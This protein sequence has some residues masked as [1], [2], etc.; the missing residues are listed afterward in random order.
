MKN[1]KSK[2]LFPISLLAL[3]VLAGCNKYLDR[4]AENRTFAAAIDY[5]KTQDM[6]QPLIGAYAAFRDRG[7]EQFPLVGVRGDDINAGGLGDQPGFMDTDNYKY[8]K[9]NWQYNSVWQTMYRDIL[10]GWASKAQIDLYAEKA[11]GSTPAEQYKA[12]IDVLNCFLLLQISRMWGNVLIPLSANPSDLLAAPVS[13]K[14][15]V[16][17]YISQTMA[18]AAQ[19]L[20]DSRPNQRTDVPGGVTKYTALAIKAIADLD[21][22]N[23]QG[24]A[25]ATGAIINSG[26][27]QLFPDFYQLFKKPGKLSNESLLELQYSDFGSGTG[28]QDVYTTAFFGPQSWKP[29]VGQINGGWAFWEPSF[30]YIKFML[31]RG[32]KTRVL[33]TVLFSPRGIDSLQGYVGNTPLPDWITNVTPSGD[34]INDYTRAVF[35]SGKF[36]LPSEQITPGRTGWANGINIQCIRYAEVLLMYA[37]ALTRGASASA[38]SADDAVNLVRARAGLSPLSGVNTNQVLDEKF[39]ELA[40]EWGSRYSDLLRT[41]KYEELSYDGKTFTA[42]K[43]YLPYP[44]A[45]VDLLPQLK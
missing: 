10:K 45:Q 26:R 7:W 38:I 4:E 11:T 39:A 8:D 27:F 17:T 30:K 43:A 32:E 21:N 19:L 29:K 1:I 36:Y 22:E 16:M 28:T 34:I 18:A 2:I 14:A 31:E 9:T 6:I 37:E 35:A 24:V 20:P 13:S 15:D 25:E 3:F 44:Q 5:T 12:E 42:D 33:G 23:Y 40:T 41:K